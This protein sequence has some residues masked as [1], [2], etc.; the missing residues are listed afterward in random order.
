MSGPLPRAVVA[1]L[2]LLLGLLALA[3]ACSSPDE[4]QESAVPFVVC[5]SS[6][7]WTR[8]SEEEQA[9][10]VWTRSR[11]GAADADKLR[12]QLYEDFFFYYGGNSEMFD[13]WPLHGLWTAEDVSPGDPACERGGPRLLWGEVI[14]VFLLLHEAKEVRFTGNTFY[15]TVE[16]GLTGFQE[17][18]FPNLLFP[19]QWTPD[20]ST[21]DGPLLD[22]N[23]AI[24]DASG[25]ELAR[26]E[27]GL[28]FE[29]LN[30]ERP[31][32]TATLV[33]TATGAG[34]TK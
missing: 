16:K 29:R 14:S 23:V 5:Q 11:Y 4:V 8:P 32:P 28:R 24:V 20:P 30:G 12:A 18:Q 25:R 31:A 13:S 33:P 3:T 6:E 22:Y 7:T 2:C 9:K 21:K 19:E 26:A 1:S 17:I 34:T 15:I 27:G 10:E